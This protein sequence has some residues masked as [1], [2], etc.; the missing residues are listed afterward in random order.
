MAILR[1]VELVTIVIFA[2]EYALRLWTAKYLYPET[3]QWRAALAFALSFFGIIDLLSFF[4][5]FLPF[6]FPKG[7]V[8]FRIFRVFRIFQLF[9]INTKY[10]AFNVIV[11]VLNEKR[12]R[13][14]IRCV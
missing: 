11:N 12:G 9:Q 7:A 1:A 2:I 6:V 14:F 5:Y 13:F 10:D 3:N 8:A 4:P